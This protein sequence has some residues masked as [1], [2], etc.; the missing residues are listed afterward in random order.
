[1]EA[2]GDRARLPGRYLM[3]PR[4]VSTA[5][6]DWSPEG[7]DV[8]AVGDRARL[9]GRYLM[10]PRHVAGCCARLGPSARITR[11]ASTAVELALAHLDDNSRRGRLLRPTGPLSANHPAG[12][13]RCRAGAGASGRQLTC[14]RRECLG[15]RD[16]I[17]R[18]DGARW[19]RSARLMQVAEPML[20]SAGM[21]GH[22]G[23]HCACG[24]RQMVAVSQ[25]DASGGTPGRT[26][27]R[28]CSR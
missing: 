5:R 24:R 9:P 28:N 26:P 13:D 14:T 6:L 7:N 23:F 19:W 27:L 1:M 8:E 17:V 15:I 4:H 16:S 2:V 11:Q 22:K 21:P 12:V 20:Y 10:D 25:A 3:D 18:V